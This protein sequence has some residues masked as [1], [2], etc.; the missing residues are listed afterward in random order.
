MFFSGG[1]YAF[2]FNIPALTPLPVLDDAVSLFY[3]AY[4]WLIASGMPAGGC[5]Q[6]LALA[7]LAAGCIYPAASV[8]VGVQSS[9]PFAGGIGIVAYLT[10]G[11]SIAKGALAALR[12]PER[13]RFK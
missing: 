9:G 10:V 1:Y 8:G 3:L 11:I 5:G 2:T 12:D 6:L 13:R 4:A 7:A